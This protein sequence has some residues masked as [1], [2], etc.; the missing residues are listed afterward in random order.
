MP[1]SRALAYCLL[2]APVAWLAGAALSPGTDADTATELATVAA[3]PDRWSAFMA[4]VAIGSL[5]LVAATPGLA[6]LCSSRLGL[7]GAALVAYGNV[8]GASDA[9]NELSLKEMVVNG[10]D[11]AQMVGL[12]DRTDE[13]V[14]GALFFMTGGLSFL[15]GGVMLAVALGRSR[16]VPAWS[17]ALFGLSFVVQLVGWSSSSDLL[18]GASA[19]ALLVA[20]IPVVA[21]LLSS[22]SAG[23]ATRSSATV[24]VQGV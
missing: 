24:A 18:V 15:V 1:A 2:A 3:H 5:A 17:A 13:S 21:R 11:R 7:V 4:L 12:L 16:A 23:V 8:I 10:A 22:S 20:V 6:R 19:G 14:P 9:I